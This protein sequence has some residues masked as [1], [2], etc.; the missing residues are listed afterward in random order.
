MKFPPI[1][2]KVLINYFRFIAAG[3]VAVVLLA[4]YLFLIAP[5]VTEVKT[6]ETTT[7]K[8]AETELKIQ[9]DFL[10]DLKKSNEKFSTTFGSEQIKAINEFIPSSPDFPGLLLTVQNIVSQARLTLDSFSVGAVGQLPSAQGASAAG[11][12]FLTQDVSISVSGGGNYAAFKNLLSLFESSRRLFDI[13]SIGYA[14]GKADEK[15]SIGWTLV[16]RTYYLPPQ[17]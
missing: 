7:R 12:T 2:N 11:V 15:S 3:A 9:Q 13:I 16:L 8:N 5:K 14:S 1:I 4:G 10:I 6:T 17:H